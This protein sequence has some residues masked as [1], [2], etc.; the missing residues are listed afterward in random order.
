MAS[1]TAL[2]PIE[3]TRKPTQ[4]STLLSNITPPFTRRLSRA[5]HITLANGSQVIDFR[6]V[7]KQKS[8]EELSTADHNIGKERAVN[9]ETAAPHVPAE[10]DD[11]DV[12]FAGPTQSEDL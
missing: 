8:S 10:L 9:A 12:I 1:S 3:K 7:L 2:P 5:R 4:T 6:E 11:A